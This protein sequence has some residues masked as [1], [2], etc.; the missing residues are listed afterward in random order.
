[1]VSNPSINLAEP[2]PLPSSFNLI[3]QCINTPFSK[4]SKQIMNYMALSLFSFGA[5][6][7]W[8]KGLT[9]RISL[10]IFISPLLWSR[11]NRKFFLSI[12]DR[13]SLIILSSF[14]YMSEL[15]SVSSCSS[16]FCSLVLGLLVVTS[17]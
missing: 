13:L 8:A 10:E 5:R 12:R 3:Y 15:K 2:F 17:P 9:V 6:K 7:L 14:T 1:M 11:F 4:K 16:T